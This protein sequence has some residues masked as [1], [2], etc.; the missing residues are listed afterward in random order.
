MN[1]W[2]SLLSG[3][4][5]KFSSVVNLIIS[6]YLLATL[7]AVFGLGTSGFDNMANVASFLQLDALSDWITHIYGG[8]TQSSSSAAVERVLAT[9]TV[10]TGFFLVYTYWR[11]Y[12]INLLP[13]S[14]LTATLCW[15]LW[16]DLDPQRSILN[17]G[18]AAILVC[19]ITSSLSPHHFSREDRLTT[20]GM[21][22]LSII[23]SFFYVVMAP[24]IWLTRQDR[25]NNTGTAEHQHKN[26]RRSSGDNPN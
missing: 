14:S 23:L 24:P 26:T 20:A 19:I 2:G 9:W 25:T 15:A 21:M 13:N 16:L 8:L 17:F 5:F 4:G 3:F 18:L 10:L 7:Q 6:A 11:G 22:L 1:D 12:P